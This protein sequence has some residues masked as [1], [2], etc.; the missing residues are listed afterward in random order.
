M[1][2]RKLDSVESI[3]ALVYDHVFMDEMKVKQRA[4]AN[5]ADNPLY[6]VIVT[7]RMYAV[8]SDGSL[9]YKAK[10]DTITIEDFYTRAFELLS[11]EGD[12]LFAQGMQTIQGVVAHIIA[13]DRGIQT[14][15]T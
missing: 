4:I 14:E 5:N 10:S 6:D 9:H 1:G 3:E 11:T 8:A 7:Y 13:L 12:A 2:I 15:V